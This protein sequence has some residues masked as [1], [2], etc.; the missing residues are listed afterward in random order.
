MR[1]PVVAL[2]RKAKVGYTADEQ[3]GL[4]LQRDVNYLAGALGCNA[5]PSISSFQ[6][7]LQEVAMTGSLLQVCLR[8][9]VIFTGWQAQVS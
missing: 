5:G 4:P 1:G 8:A 3:A 6:L 2:M 7:V 9:K